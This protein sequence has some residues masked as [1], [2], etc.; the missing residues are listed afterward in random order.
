MSKYPIIPS[1][2]YATENNTLS[3]QYLNA[4]YDSINSWGLRKLS[5]EIMRDYIEYFIVGGSSSTNRTIKFTPCD[6]IFTSSVGNIT[7]IKVEYTDFDPGEDPD[8]YDIIT[9]DGSTTDISLGTDALT[10]ITTPNSISIQLNDISTSVSNIMTSNVPGYLSIRMTTSSGKETFFT[11]PI[12]KGDSEMSRY[13]NGELRLI[14]E[15]PISGGS[16]TV[17]AVVE[18]PNYIDNADRNYSWYFDGVADASTS[19]NTITFTGLTTGTHNVTCNL[20]DSVLAEH[21]EA[22]NPLSISFTVYNSMV[23]DS[24]MMYLSPNPMYYCTNYL[25]FHGGSVA[26]IITI[27]NSAINIDSGSYDITLSLNNG[28][29]II[30][31]GPTTLNDFIEDILVYD[32]SDINLVSTSWHGNTVTFNIDSTFTDDIKIGIVLNTAYVEEVQHGFRDSS[33]SGVFF[34]WKFKVIDG[35]STA[36]EFSFINTVTCGSDTTPN[37]EVTHSPKP[38]S[39]ADG[40]EYGSIYVNVDGLTSGNASRLFECTQSTSESDFTYSIHIKRISGPDFYISDYMA[41]P[42]Q[43]IPDNTDTLISDDSWHELKKQDGTNF[44]SSDLLV[45]LSTIKFKADTRGSIVIAIKIK[46]TYVGTGCSSTASPFIPSIYFPEDGPFYIEHTINVLDMYQNLPYPRVEGNILLDFSPSSNDHHNNNLEITT[47]ETESSEKKLT[48]MT[49]YPKART[50]CLYLEPSDTYKNR[51][52]SCTEYHTG[53]SFK[54]QAMRVVVGSNIYKPERFETYPFGSSD[55]PYV[56]GGTTNSD[57]L[58]HSSSTNIVKIDPTK[59][60]TVFDDRD[61]YLSIRLADSTSTLYISYEKPTSDYLVIGIIKYSVHTDDDG[62]SVGSEG[63]IEDINDYISNNKF[64]NRSTEIILPY[65]GIPIRGFETKLPITGYNKII[66]PREVRTNTRLNVPAI[67]TSDLPVFNATSSEAT[68]P[69][70]AFGAW[71]ESDASHKKRPA[72]VGTIASSGNVPSASGSRIKMSTPMGDFIM[73]DNDDYKIH[74][75]PDIM[76]SFYVGS[77]GTI[78]KNIPTTLETEWISEGEPD[79]KTFNMVPSGSPT[80]EMYNMKSKVWSFVSDAVV[81]LQP[82][83]MP[84]ISDTELHLRGTY[85]NGVVTIAHHI[86]NGEQYKIIPVRVLV[87]GST[88]QAFTADESSGFTITGPS[89]VRGA[90]SYDYSTDP[91]GGGIT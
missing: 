9:P 69:F 74:N 12:K 45:G 42:S 16:A 54:V 14:N 50:V 52:F 58:S 39:I 22:L 33:D 75:I 86:K 30:G 17:K 53:G 4:V 38:I 32:T 25:D 46:A 82:I 10:D 67:V 85:S 70:Y 5:A 29:S 89:D 18:W 48:P 28:D 11:I 35:L 73:H 27:P 3:V 71:S 66:T 87:I 80:E 37:L 13:I 41:L 24:S 55:V 26:G 51:D 36:Q 23:I 20:V 68:P 15:Y 40:P 64:W 44:S 60:S 19:T 47:V 61:V 63:N 76:T 84:I 72:S 43:P 2:L 65:G 21:E 77:D 7:K 81:M 91:G 88:A 31:D 59:D 1:N 78:Y 62:K 49:L 34:D 8:E 6:I 83:F 56:N 79:P 90:D 57:D